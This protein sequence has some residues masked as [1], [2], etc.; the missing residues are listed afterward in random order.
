[1][2]AWVPAASTVVT[3]TPTTGYFG[4]AVFQYTAVAPGAAVSA[5][6]TVSLTVGTQAPGA[7]AAAMTVQLNTPGTLDLAPF[8]TGS[9]ITGVQIASNPTKGTVLLRR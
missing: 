7:G 3:F 8:I 9:A 1:M 4:P 2:G 5:A 6:A